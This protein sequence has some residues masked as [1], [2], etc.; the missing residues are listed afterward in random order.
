[1]PF[2]P[3]PRRPCRETPRVT[4]SLQRI[5]L[6]EYSWQS[7]SRRSSKLPGPPASL[8]QETKQP[9]LS[10]RREKVFSH[11]LLAGVNFETE[12]T[13]RMVKT[14]IGSNHDPNHLERRKGR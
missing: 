5:H 2:D 1:S 9:S 10:R 14:R 11:V 13:E 3:E 8:N 7:F 4:V 6:R 12:S